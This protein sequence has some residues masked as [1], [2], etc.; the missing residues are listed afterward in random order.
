MNVKNYLLFL[1]NLG[2]SNEAELFAESWGVEYRSSLC[3]PFIFS[4]NMLCNGNNPKMSHSLIVVIQVLD[5]YLFIVVP[6]SDFC[7]NWTI[8]SH[9]VSDPDISGSDPDFWPIRI[10][11][12]EKKP[13]RT[14]GPGSE[15]LVSHSFYFSGV[16]SS[17]FGLSRSQNFWPAPDRYPV[18]LYH[19]FWRKKTVL[20]KGFEV[21]CE[22]KF[23]SLIPLPT[24]EALSRSR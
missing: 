2:R 21:N 13:I 7:R 4:K 19:T 14:K 24:A 22:K 18:L 20:F 15:T 16:E 9:S 11:T 1:P 10:R 6:T 17:F 8:V 3:R 23:F 12:E 5:W